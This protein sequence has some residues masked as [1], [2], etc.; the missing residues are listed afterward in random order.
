[1]D[2]NGLISVLKHS[3][4]LLLE[5]EG[6]NVSVWGNLKHNKQDL[7]LFLTYNLAELQ[8]AT[9]NKKLKT[10]VCSSNET[11]IHVLTKKINTNPKNDKPV[12]VKVSKKN[13]F[14]THDKMSVLTWDLMDMKFKTVDLSNW[15]VSN[16]IPITDDNIIL[17]DKVIKEILKKN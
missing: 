2:A 3:D 12:E 8:Y 15:Y 17:L 10:I 16:F 13:K 7:E 14:K 9:K 6:E 5:S 11:L 1:M 4:N